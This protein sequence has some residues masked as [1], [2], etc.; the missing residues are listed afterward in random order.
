[1]SLVDILFVY[2]FPC[3]FLIL[4]QILINA[5]HSLANATRRLLVITHTGH[6]CAHANLDLSEMGMIVQVTV[7]SW[8]FLWMFILITWQAM[9]YFF[10]LSD[11][12]TQL[13]VFK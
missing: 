6:T 9:F 10:K 13:K 7:S 11:T 2:I 5:K 4:R 1:M 12:V 8:F 3:F